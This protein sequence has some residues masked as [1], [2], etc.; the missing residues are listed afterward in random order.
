MK[1]KKF[2]AVFLSV[3][4]L[5]SFC[6]FS[7]SA[8]DESDI[9]ALLE[10]F[11]FGK[12]PEVN[13]Y[14][15]DYRYFSPVKEGDGTQYPLVIWLHGM[16]DGAYDGKQVESSNIALW[17]SEE[18][19]L[20]FKESEG[21]FILA[22]RSV[23]E[24]GLFWSDDLIHPLRAAIDAFICEN[25]YN[26]DLSRIYVGGYSMGGKMTL[27]MAVAYPELFA[28]AFPICPA[29]VP[30][31]DATAK[32]ADMPIW[33]TSGAADP[34]VNYFTWVM[35]T[36]KNIVSQSNCP[37]LCRFSTLSRTAYANGLPTASSHHSWF[38][39]N[40]DM[41]SSRDG[42]YPAM[43]TVDGNGNKIE[44]T[45]PE[46]MISWLSGFRSDF[47]GSQATDSGNSEA[48]TSNGM[49]TGFGML[50]TFL[51]N[52]FEYILSFIGL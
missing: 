35:P 29:W 50:I 49:S 11:V 1:F 16:G 45:F 14:A 8:A 47:D 6:A 36:W 38:A 3:L 18:Y 20:R 30:G 43:K 48:Q 27:K 12:G 40:N 9:D 28:A 2:T 24:Q 33:L 17:A 42:D 37:E 41:F 44:L 26:I 15:I 46:G 5:F 52:F 31:T 4:M 51:K 21:A 7:V 19:Q 23:E 25:Q 13:G 34:I 32:L 10:K 22:A 39:V